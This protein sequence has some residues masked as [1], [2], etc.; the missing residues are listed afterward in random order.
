MILHDASPGQEGEVIGVNPEDIEDYG[1][2]H[3]SPTEGTL[4]MLHNGDKL[5]VQETVM[6]IEQMIQEDEKH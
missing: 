3:A 5:L 2:N 4:V 1:T 6:E